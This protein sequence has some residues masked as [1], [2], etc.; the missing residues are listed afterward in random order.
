MI[1]VNLIGDES[2]RWKKKKRKEYRDRF[3][4]RH[5]NY[6]R[7]YQK[8][9]RSMSI[10]E[11]TAW[12][13]RERNRHRD[14]NLRSCLKR[15]YGMTLEDYNAMLSRQ[16]GRCAACGKAPPVGGKRLY[17]DH[18]HATGNVRGLLCQHCNSAIGFA[19]D[20]VSVLRS[21]ISYLENT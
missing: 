16:S 11:R 15:Y 20:D 6:Q 10:E 21:L 19:G 18:D 8:Q 1:S 5:P 13:L 9:W 17:V 7:G 12:R 2:E 3:N 14:S 4:A